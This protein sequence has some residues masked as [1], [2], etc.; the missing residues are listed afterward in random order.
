MKCR[1]S[2]LESTYIDGSYLE[3][4][5]TAVVCP[6]FAGTLLYCEG[7]RILSPACGVF[8]KSAFELCLY[9]FV[10]LLAVRV[11]SALVWWGCA[12]EERQMLLSF[13]RLSFGTITSDCMP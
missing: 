1:Q 12:N 3:S 7:V 2:F 10:T 5:S 9:V 13:D 4:T 6:L 8:T 11:P